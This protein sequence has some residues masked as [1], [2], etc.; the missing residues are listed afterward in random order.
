MK[1][2]AM[3][4]LRI[5]ILLFSI[6]LISGKCLAQNDSTSVNEYN[7]SLSELMSTKV[8]VAGKETPVSETP[9]I[10]SIIT[11][12]EIEASGAKDMIGILRLVPGF[13]F[14]TEWDNILGIGIRG[15]NATEG[16]FLIM[17]DGNQLNETNYGI[18]PFGGHIVPENI[19]RVEIIRGSGSVIYGGAAELS[20]INIITLSGEDINGVSASSRVSVSEKSLSGRN[21]QANCGFKEKNGLTYSIAAYNSLVNRSNRTITTLDS[22]TINYKDSSEI[23]SSNIN[24]KTSYKGFNA[25]FLYDQ[26]ASN[27]TEASGKILFEG[28]YAKA[29]QKI[30][31][32]EKILIKPSVFFMSQKPWYFVDFSEKEFYNT[33]NNRYRV[34]VPIQISFKG[35]SYL[36]IGGEAY[37]DQSKK[38]VD[39]VF[40]SSTGK[41][42]ISYNGYSIYEE[43][44]VLSKYVN[45][46]LG[47]RIEFHNVYGY[48]FVPRLALVKTWKS[49]YVKLLVSRAFK[50]PTIANIDYNNSILP[51]KTQIIELESGFLLKNGL[52]ISTNIFDIKISD[53]ILYIPNPM[54]GA[55]F[56]TNFDKTGSRGIE[57]SS[58]YKDKWGILNLSYSYYQKNNNSVDAYGIENV[59]KTY[60]AF[61]Q[62]KASIWSQIAL[63]EDISL[64][65][66][67][68][69]F[70][71]RYTYIHKDKYWSEAELM[72]YNQTVLLNLFIT[73]RNLLVKGLDCS[74]GVYD[75]TN[76]QYEFINAYS[77]WQNQIPAQGREL[78]LKLKYTFVREANE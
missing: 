22:T 27:N 20:V 67:I 13:S 52:A 61:P 6:L 37:L 30:D 72:T 59:P 53:P 66:A 29:E 43:L 10:I 14:G 5:K 2:S 71:K 49:G 39:S 23:S 64:S 57:L 18:F 25:Q 46:T 31:I 75:L 40:F 56:Y 42:E 47:S 77:G 1:N 69:F 74:F 32:Q 15:N 21:I 60:G 50:A 17:I 34:S 26:F 45:L 9:A 41:N 54:T 36:R 76:Q 73:Y 63:D 12:E 16:K 4:N 65:C 48:A 8:S 38:Q 35:G 70:G 58:K 3:L 62:H 44:G 68:N 28:I 55:D 11:R 51:E 24:L 19:A 33:I 78:S 7:L